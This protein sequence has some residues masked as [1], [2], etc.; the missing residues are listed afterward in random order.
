[1]VRTETRAAYREAILDAATRV[2]GRLGFHDAK[3]ADIAAEAGVAAGTVYN[4]FKNKE[5]VFRSILER[6]HETVYQR[7]LVH[8]VIDDPLERMRAS[9]REA[10]TFL[11]QH[12]AM[13]L[14]YISIGGAFDWAQK[15]VEQAIMDEKHA[16]YL[17]MT[18][19]TLRDAVSRGQIRGD[20][21]LERLATYLSGLTDAT[22][23]AWVRAGCPPG[24]ERQADPMIDFFLHGARAP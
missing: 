12:G 24:L 18:T 21:A 3:M 8:Q 6:G 19:A 23:F 22:I 10:F 11:E 17:A 15:R 9:T 1:M 14:L 20:V 16:R 13:F 4:Y 5:E 7:I 2:F